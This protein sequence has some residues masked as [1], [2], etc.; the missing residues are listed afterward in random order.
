MTEI[1]GY[2]R[3]DI[4]RLKTLSA[5]GVADA[6]LSLAEHCR[7]KGGDPNEVETLLL[8]AVSQGSAVAAMS[9]GNYYEMVV[10]DLIRA[11]TA[12]DRSCEM[13]CGMA[14]TVLAL[15]HLSGRLGLPVDEQRAKQYSVRA[16]QLSGSSGDS[17]CHDT[18]PG[19]AA[20]G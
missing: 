4:E 15:A 14:C 2:S 20:R 7:T 8:L 17:R 13:G 19:P 9:L 3:E 11:V 5:S 12:Y 18:P 6:T 1:V 16:A 10:G